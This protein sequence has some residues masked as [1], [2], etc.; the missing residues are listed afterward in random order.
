MNYLK[1]RRIALNLSQITTCHHGLI[2]RA[3]YQRLEAGC[4]TA[5]PEQAAALQELLGV[6]VL[7]DR[8]LIN[9]RQRRE[10]CAFE[11]L[12]LERVNPE[13]WKRAR[14]FWGW[15]GADEPARDFLSNFVH[16]DSA[17]EC[18][19]HLACVRGGAQLK[20][21]SPL[22]WGFNKHL[23]LDLRGASLGVCHWPCLLYKD[24]HITLCYWPQLTLKSETAVYRIDGL[25]YCNGQWFILELDGTGHDPTFNETRAKILGLQEIRFTSQELLK[26][27]CFRLLLERLKSQ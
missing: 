14:R 4:T 1:L 3:G 16:A 22:F 11:P 25:L 10:L 19:F 8:H 2:S 27:D 26:T 6:P 18:K 15:Q 20:V 9:G 7:T 24:E 21:D 5:T 17:T 13:P 12:R 23:L